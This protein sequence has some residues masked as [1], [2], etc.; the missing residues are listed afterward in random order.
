MTKDELSHLKIGDL[1]TVVART[2]KGP[3]LWEDARV[4]LW[5]H[6]GWKNRFDDDDSYI[7]FKTKETNPGLLLLHPSQIE[8]VIIE[9]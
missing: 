5:V 4:H 6:T 9:G 7:S 2:A 3:L 8:R 1:V